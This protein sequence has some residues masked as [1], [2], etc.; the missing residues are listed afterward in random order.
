[1]D[2]HMYFRIEHAYACSTPKHI[3]DG[4]MMCVCI[5]K[6]HRLNENPVFDPYLKYSF[7]NQVYI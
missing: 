2:S 5:L 4:P 1:M 3:C 7:K 6:I